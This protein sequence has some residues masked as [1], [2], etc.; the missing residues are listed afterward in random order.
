MAPSFSHLDA[1]NI[2]IKVP[3]DEGDIRPENID[4]W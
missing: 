4:E 2:A 3:I 1:P